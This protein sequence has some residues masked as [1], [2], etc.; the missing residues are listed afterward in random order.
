MYFLCSCFVRILRISN[1]IEKYWLAA[2]ELNFTME[3]VYWYNVLETLTYKM[4]PF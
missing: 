1:V 3:Q 4:V 2:L